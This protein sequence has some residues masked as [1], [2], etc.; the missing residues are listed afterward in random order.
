M[1]DP[2]IAVLTE[3]W[4][5]DTV[6]D[7]EFVPTGYSSYRKDRDGRGGGVSILFK[8]T[9]RIFPM[10]DIP[11]VE[12]IFCKAYYGNVRY[13]IAAMYRPPS[14]TVSVL[15]DLKQYLYTNVKLGDR[16]I[17]S[18]DF[19]LPNI[20]WSTFS[21]EKHDALGE[22]MLDIAFSFDLLQIVEQSTRIQGSSQSVL[23]LF[24]VSG[25][26][27]AD[28]N[29]EIVPGISDH[30]AVLLTIADAVLDSKPK[31][32]SYPNFSRADDVSIIDILR[33]TSM[34]F[35]IAQMMCIRFGAGLKN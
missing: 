16:I 26:I 4:L 13:V 15:D 32:P 18:G 35:Q 19:N 34:P 20:D 27:G 9:L 29:Y 23:D 6:F 28:T 24:F 22:A 25:S 8:S 21:L 10:S 11:N 7:S 12:C 33:L 2:E 14:S 31:Y 5:N 17:L 1:H 3:T 30:E